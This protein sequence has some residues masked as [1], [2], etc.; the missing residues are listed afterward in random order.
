MVRSRWFTAFSDRK[1]GSSISFFARLIA[2]S[3]MLGRNSPVSG[4]SSSRRICFI[5][6][7]W[8]S[9]S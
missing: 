5:S 6:D 7:C 1:V 3:T 2:P 8:S 9:V 4:M